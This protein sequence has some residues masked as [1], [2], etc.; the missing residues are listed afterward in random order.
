MDTLY[1]YTYIRCMGLCDGRSIRLSEYGDGR[2]EYHIGE[3]GL[4]KERHP[5]LELHFIH[6]LGAVRVVSYYVGRDTGE[7][8]LGKN[9]RA[10][11]ELRS[12]REREQQLALLFFHCREILTTCHA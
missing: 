8:R 12:D 9:K 11:L 3:C 10:I 7:C 2:P 1:V 6:L 4:E 5:L